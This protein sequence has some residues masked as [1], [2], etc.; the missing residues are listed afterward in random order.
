MPARD[1]HVAVC[2][3]GG[4]FEVQLQWNILGL[5]PGLGD[6]AGEGATRTEVGDEE[7][8]QVGT[9]ALRFLLSDEHTAPGGRKG[10]LE[11]KRRS[12][13]QPDRSPLDGP[14]QGMTRNIERA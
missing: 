11:M 2:G 12:L 1:D 7:L 3:N 13:R 9:D 6:V 10:A 8:P 5:M 4:R 14:L